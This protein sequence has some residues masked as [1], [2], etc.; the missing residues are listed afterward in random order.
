MRIIRECGGGLTRGWRGLRERPVWRVA[1]GQEE[2]G[3]EPKCN[4]HGATPKLCSTMP[5]EFRSEDWVQ[6]AGQRSG[7]AR[8]ICRVG[9][10]DPPEA[11][12]GR[13]GFRLAFA[14]GSRRPGRRTPIQRG[15]F[16]SNETTG[17]ADRMAVRSAREGERIAKNGRRYG[18]V[19]WERLFHAS[20]P[21]CG[22]RQVGQR[23]ESERSGG[24]CHKDG[25]H[26]ENARRHQHGFDPRRSSTGRVY[27][28][29]QT[30]AVTALT[31]QD[32]EK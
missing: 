24:T 12:I 3:D 5:D 27:A 7:P 15:L 30:T 21:R 16:P 6:G 22:S 23:Q 32:R 10:R 9:R 11:P 17:R 31:A 13:I 1:A 28:H 20:N 4:F 18:R 25:S 19:H 2:C 29:G 14:R 26:W 8:W